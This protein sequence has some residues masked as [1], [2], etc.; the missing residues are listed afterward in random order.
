M[1]GTAARFL[2][3]SVS[4]SGLVVL[5]WVLT[6]EAARPANRGIPLPTD[7]SHSH[8]IFSRPSTEEQ[9]RTVAED[10]RY[11]QQLHRQADS[12]ALSPEVSD[13]PAGKTNGRAANGGL[14]S[15]N[16]G[17][18]AAPGPGNYPAK[19]AFNSTVANC[20]S[21][22]T[23]DYVVYSTGLLGS[24]TQASVVAYDNL[25]QGCG[26]P[27]P[28]TYWAYNTGGLILTSPFTSLDGTQ[29]AFAQTSG[30]PSGQAGLLLLKWKA[31]ATE[32]VTTPGVPTLVSNALYPTCVAPCMTE[33]FLKDGS[34]IAVDDRTSSPFYDYTND[35]AW[36]GGGNGWLHKITGVFKGT[37]AAPPKEVH[38]GGFPAQMSPP[39]T[40]T[41][42]DPVY[43]RVTKNVFVADAGGF[44]YRVAS[45]TGAVTKSAQLDFGAGFPQSP[46]LDQT[47]GRLFVFSS[48]DGTT[49]STCAP[50]ACSAI[51]LLGTSFAAGTAGTKVTVG[52]SVV[53]GSLPNPNPLYIGGFDSTYFGSVGGTGNLYVCGNTGSVPTLYRVPITPGSFGPALAVAQLARAATTPSCSPVTEF[54]N[55]STSV[56]AAEHVYFSV[57]G[58]GLACAN[59]GCI[60]NFVDMPWQASTHYNVG[61]QILILRAADNT[62]YLNVA[63][64]SGTSGAT[65]PVWPAAPGTKKVDSG[66]TW[67]NQGT[68]NF[69]PLA[70]WATGNHGAQARILD[71]NGNVEIIIVAGAS[72]ATAPVWN[73]TV[74][75]TTIDNKVTWINAGP[76]S[77]AA[78]TVTSGTG[79]IIVD[80]SVNS[81]TLAG[82]S[83]VYFFTLGNQLCT[84]SGTTGGCAMQASQSTLQ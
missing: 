1:N 21:A 26:A 48:S 5:G 19:F 9:M 7:W 36:V 25:Y 82:A 49:A 15:E 79:G 38:G 84:T 31:S 78:M 56:G 81:G 60:M 18:N 63:V 83:Q 47:N 53:T 41:L 14:W 33:V 52:K 2:R 51:F 75:G 24:G 58:H 68:I 32:T 29:V 73:T 23:P 44:F 57:Q 67:L 10:P 3:L 42:S 55:R 70:G 39:S 34:N 16:L 6:G 76:W 27:V 61:Q 65:I 45:A 72:G 80:N 35:I 11:W 12:R 59:K 66:V 46:V 37:A 4:L 77:N 43:D 74:G 20:A 71:S 64:V 40:N 54:S 17:N 8:V 28:K 69:T 22:A 13:L 30:S 62:V 50:A